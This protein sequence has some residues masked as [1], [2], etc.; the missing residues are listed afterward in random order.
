M[1][2]TAPNPVRASDAER[3]AVVARLHA[4]LGEGRLDLAE[5]EERVAAAYAARY[6]HEL[7]ATLAD[8]PDADTAPGATPRSA[9]AARVVAALGVLLTELLTDA[10]TVASGATTRQ[11]RLAVVALVVWLLVCGLLGAVLG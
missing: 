5:T 6:R 7:P 11:R 3:E 8:L 4:A 1:S 9:T 2:T 10:R